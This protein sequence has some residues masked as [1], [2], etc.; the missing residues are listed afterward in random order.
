MNHVEV[1]FSP[2]DYAL[3]E[4]GFELVVVIDVLRATSAICTALENG[5]A[6]IKPVAHV[7]EAKKWQ[8]KANRTIRG[9]AKQ[10]TIL[11]F[12]IIYTI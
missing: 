6:R 9:N 12:K 2:A 3:Y 8:S 5:I 4:S 1:C 7:E 10:A 11:Q